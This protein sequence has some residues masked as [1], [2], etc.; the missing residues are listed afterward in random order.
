MKNRRENNCGYFTNLIIHKILLGYKYGIAMYVTDLKNLNLP[1]YYICIFLE[2]EL[3]LLSTVGI[4]YHQ[5]LRTATSILFV[6]FSIIIRLYHQ[7]N[8][9]R[10]VY[11]S[12]VCLVLYIYCTVCVICVIHYHVRIYPIAWVDQKVPPV[13]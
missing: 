6:F 13:A 8:G 1:V 7:V 3:P 9:I 10:C 11:I 5:Y 2:L 4:L 12:Q